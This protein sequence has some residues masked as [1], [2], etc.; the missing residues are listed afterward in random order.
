LAPAALPAFVATPDPSATV[1]PSTA[2]PGAPVIRSTWLRRF[3]DGARTAS[4]VA[5]PALRHRAVPTTPPKWPTASVRV[6]PVMRPSP[7]TKGLGLRIIFFSRPLVGSLALRPGDS[8]TIP[9]MA[10]SVGFLRFV[11][12]TEATQATGVLTI[13]L[14]GLTPTGQV[15]LTWTHSLPKFPLAGIHSP[16]S[17]RH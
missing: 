7:R 5:R 10:W 17:Y 13:P 2:F 1:S 4:P 12:S 14:V 3:R 8:L 11:S 6:P 15:S 9:K 16:D